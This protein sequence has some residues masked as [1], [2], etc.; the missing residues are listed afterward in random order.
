MYLG[1]IA[2][3][4]IMALIDAAPKPLLLSGKFTPLLN[5]QWGLDTSVMSDIE[6][7]WEGEKRSEPSS[8]DHMPP[9][10]D[11]DESKLS[12]NTKARLQRVRATM[13]QR[14]GYEDDDVTLR[15]A[16]VSRLIK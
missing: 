4:I 9:F 16:A 14:L 11:F 12:D 1:E 7:A 3:N 10:T 15:D 2:R 13:V 6:N 8:E 5:T